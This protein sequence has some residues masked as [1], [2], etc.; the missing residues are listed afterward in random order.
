MGW[1]LFSDSCYFFESNE[2]NVTSAEN[3]CVEKDSH[4]VSIHSIK[5]MNFLRDQKIFNSEWAW[6]GGEKKGNSFQWLDGTA[7]DYKNWDH[8]QPDNQWWDKCILWKS[9]SSSTKWHGASCTRE[10]P[11]VCKKPATRKC[12][13]FRIGKIFK[14]QLYELI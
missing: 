6:I 14:A 12:F 5:E 1:F 4:L 8:G 3:D 2:K 7:F 11:Y 13:T 10:Y 9:L